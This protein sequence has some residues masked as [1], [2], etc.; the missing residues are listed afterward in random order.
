MTNASGSGTDSP[1]RLMN[2]VPQLVTSRTGPSAEPPPVRHARTYARKAVRGIR[3]NTHSD[4]EPALRV[5]CGGVIGGGR[6]QDVDRGEDRTVILRQSDPQVWCY[7][8][9]VPERLQLTTTATAR[10]AELVTCV[11][12]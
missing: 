5:R 9:A 8:A 10:G 3:A 4:T 7:A 2:H 12:V 1:R 11:A 6:G